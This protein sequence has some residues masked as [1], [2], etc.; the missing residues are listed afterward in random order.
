MREYYIE[1]SKTDVLSPIHLRQYPRIDLLAPLSHLLDQLASIA[2]KVYRF[3]DT[4][5][6]QLYR[7]LEIVYRVSLLLL[8]AVM[9]RLFLL[10][11]VV[12]LDFLLYF[13]LGT[14]GVLAQRC[15]LL[16]DSCIG[17]IFLV[18]QFNLESIHPCEIFELQV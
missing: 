7:L 14:R 11:L 9:L 5:V 8:D 10:L 1:D 6:D 3:K 15:C 4:V 2:L 17:H 16:A 12:L 13:Y 18:E